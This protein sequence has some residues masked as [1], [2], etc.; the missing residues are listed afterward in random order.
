VTARIH[1]C[2]NIDVNPDTGERDIRLL[3]LLQE[4]F[5]HTQTGVLAQVISSGSVAIGDELIV[6]SES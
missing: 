2:L 6:D 4:Q 1:R 5:Q 3:S